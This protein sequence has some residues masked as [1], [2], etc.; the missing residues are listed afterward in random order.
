M[1]QV[2]KNKQKFVKTEDGTEVLKSKESRQKVRRWTFEAD[3]QIVLPAREAVDDQPAVAEQ[4]MPMRTMKLN[5]LHYGT[6]KE[7]RGAALEQQH[8][9]RGTNDMFKRAILHVRTIPH[10]TVSE[11]TMRQMLG[12]RDMAG[13][14]DR[15]LE[16]AIV[17]AQ[18][19]VKGESLGVRFVE[20]DSVPAVIENGEVVKRGIPAR[21][22]RDL[23][24]DFYA[25]AVREKTAE[26]SGEP[27][28]EP[29]VESEE[30]RVPFEPEIVEIQRTADVQ[31][32]A[33]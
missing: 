10:E 33:V 18:D 13:L 20:A 28:S 12:Y 2:G 9:L 4:V 29:A 11:E 5:G 14:L 21:V 6:A 8:A 22:M 24:E 30:E 15:A 27:V 23:K 19:I 32:V 17:E 3:I 1:D 26:L 7:A 31:A 16:L 25:Q